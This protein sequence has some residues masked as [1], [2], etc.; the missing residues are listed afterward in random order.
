MLFM[1]TSVIICIHKFW[2]GYNIRWLI[3]L[4]K[5]IFEL[6][7]W[8][9]VILLIN[10][11]NYCKLFAPP[12]FSHFW[13]DLKFFDCFVKYDVSFLLYFLVYDVSSIHI[14]T[15]FLISNILFFKTLFLNVSVFNFIYTWILS[16]YIASVNLYFYVTIWNRLI[17][18]KVFLFL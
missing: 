10:V 14:H 12:F 13:G 6:G 17:S 5:L 8:C 2:K 18:F 11:P 1:S 15:H 9:N 4:W 7:L 3:L 16:K